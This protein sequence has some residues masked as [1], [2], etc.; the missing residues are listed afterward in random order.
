[1]NRCPGA[2]VPCR[3]A[4]TPTPGPD[5]RTRVRKKESEPATGLVR[6]L[7]RTHHQMLAVLAFSFVISGVTVGYDLLVAQPH[8]ERYVD[9]AIETQNSRIGV[10]EQAAALRGWLATDDDK[11]LAD[12]SAAEAGA[13]R[14]LGR[15]VRGVSGDDTSGLTDAVVRTATAR[16]AW[17]V[18]AESM[19]EK[20]LAASRDR[21]VIQDELRTGRTLL[22]D[23]LD[24]N[25]ESAELTIEEQ[26]AALDHMRHV[27]LAG[28]L[29]FVAVLIATAVSTVR[30]RRTVDRQV[31]T[32]FKGLLH[33]IE[34]LQ[35]GD[36]AARSAA[37]GVY[38]LNQIAD[39][40]AGLATSADNARQEATARERRLALLATRFETVTRVGREI[41]GSL[42]VRY[43]ASTVTSAASDLTGGPTTLWL[44]SEDQAFHAVSRS[45]DRHGVT[46][47]A[48]LRPSEAVAVA[49][50]EARTAT[51]DGH[52]AYPLVL[53]GMVVSVLEAP[54]TAV[55]PDTE[56]VLEVLL[57]TA[58]AAL[59]SA[60][61]HSATKELA[62]V[63]ALTRLPNRRR[64][65]GDIEAEWDRCRRYGR[66]LSMIMLDLDHF[67]ALN[68]EH[69]H[70][71]GDEVLRATSSALTEVMRASDTAYRYGG[72]E[73]AI[74]LRETGLEDAEEVAERL[75]AAVAAFEAARPGVRVTASL[76]VA[77]RLSTM[78][79]HTEL[80]AKADT[81]L[82]AAKNRGR[83]RV[84]VA[85]GQ[86]Q[87]A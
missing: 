43:V 35:A 44:R 29:P 25:D 19:I 38:E 8:H 18:W 71:Y 33:T 75:R 73:F 68:D 3:C 20:D 41:S 83:D 46:P 87:P 16:T 54:N 37:S 61:L 47:P 49:A 31:V 11:Y 9:L 17:S 57:S 76:G 86:P 4:P 36:L 32:P 84:V 81:A 45:D 55:D 78:S 39:A 24:A 21:A 48:E 12:F 70:V 74:L 5:E 58:A 80:V 13:D 1:M 27:L 82:Y 67:K 50:A 6:E 22:R 23:F 69:G 77:E 10:L 7:L 28:F 51:G 79:H 56:Q 42:S 52:R 2:R 66:P 53:A 72:E 34:R 15:V 60:H 59:E 85:D 62:H 65:D 26:Q 30:R 14:A 63:D 64:F 40:L